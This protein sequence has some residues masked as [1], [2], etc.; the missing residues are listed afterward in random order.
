MYWVKKNRLAGS[1]IPYMEGEIQEWVMSGVRRVIVLP[2]DWEIEEAWGDINYYFSI[3]RK[4]KLEFIHVPIEDNMP[5]TMEQFVEILKWIKSNNSPLLVHCVGG[6]GRTGTILSSILTLEGLSW[7]ESIAN[8][9]KV[10]EGAVQSYQQM[11]FVKE[12]EE[13]REWLKSILYSS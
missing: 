2:Q 5:P 10:R 8:V 11:L 7:E 12:V 6:I 1:C 13:K 3:L 4:Y 9:R